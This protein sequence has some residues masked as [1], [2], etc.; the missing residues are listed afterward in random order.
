MNHQQATPLT[1]EVTDDR[2][3]AVINGLVA[4]PLLIVIML[5]A[6]NKRVM[7]ERVNGR[8]AKLLGW[9]ATIV[10]WAAEFGMILTWGT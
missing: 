4:P 6:N 9:I 1:R 2:R 10:M 3:Y 8:W 7:G 5:V